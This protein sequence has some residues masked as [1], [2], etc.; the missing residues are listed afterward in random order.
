MSAPKFDPTQVNGV[1]VITRQPATREGTGLT[2]GQTITLSTVDEVLLADDTT[3]FQC[4]YPGNGCG[5]VSDNHRSIVSHQRT[6]APRMEAKRLA[7]Q[8]E[9]LAAELREVEAKKAQTFAN[10]SAGAKKAYEARRLAAENPTPGAPEVEVLTSS[11]VL[12]TQRQMLMAHLM[13]MHGT[14]QTLSHQLEQ[15]IDLVTSLPDVERDLITKADG[16]DRMAELLSSITT[17]K[18]NG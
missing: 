8:N 9:K 6:H 5:M 7:A 16:Y 15:M 13:D 11:P 10:R 1:A 17:P 12:P 4:V 18:A 14:A 3:V 2:E